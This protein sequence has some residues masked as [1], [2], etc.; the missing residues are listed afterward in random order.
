MRRTRSLVPGN[1]C[2]TATLA[3][4]IG[5]GHHELLTA[6]IQA[7][8]VGIPVF[9]RMGGGYGPRLVGGVQGGVGV[10]IDIHY[11][12][13]VAVDAVRISYGLCLHIG[14][15]SVFPFGYYRGRGR[16]LLPMEGQRHLAALPCLSGIIARKRYPDIR[17]DSS[18]GGGLH[19]EGLP[20][21]EHHGIAGLCRRFGHRHRTVENRDFARTAEY[22]IAR[23]QGQHG[24]G[25]GTGDLQ[26]GERIAGRKIPVPFHEE[27]DLLALVSK[28]EGG[29]RLGSGRGFA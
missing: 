18:P 27:P 8:I 19:R 1:G 20:R 23:I 28:G 17:E 11:H 25:L 2:R 4:G 6:G 26:R 15:T 10:A 13:G 12:D 5:L 16:D 29:L 3:F 9:L 14:F 7:R 24:R 21:F 22:H